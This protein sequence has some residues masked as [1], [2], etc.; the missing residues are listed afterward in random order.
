MKIILDDFYM[1]EKLYALRDEWR[2]IEEKRKTPGLTI[3]YITGCFD[4][5]DSIEK[6]MLRLIFTGTDE[7]K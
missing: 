2:G 3:E 1:L 5:M 4:E 7:S 6:R